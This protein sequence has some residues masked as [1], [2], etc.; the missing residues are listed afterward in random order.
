MVQS[1]VKWYKRKELYGIVGLAI[2]AVKAVTG[3][4]TVAHQ[5]ADYILY[6]MPAILTVF[7]IK[8][9][10]KINKGEIK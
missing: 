3:P 8:S 1:K 5:L 4:Q 7:G 10:R 6:S 2:G 9:A